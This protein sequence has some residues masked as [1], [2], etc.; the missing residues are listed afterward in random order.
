MV[1]REPLVWNIQQLGLM[2][3]FRFK[4]LDDLLTIRC[5]EDNIVPKTDDYDV[6]NILKT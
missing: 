6:L 3:W 5:N 2:Y 1:Y 4:K